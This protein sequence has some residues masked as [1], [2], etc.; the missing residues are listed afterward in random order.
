MDYLRG[1]EWRRWDLHLHTPETKKNDQYPGASA[2]EKW[3]AFY[4]A[5]ASY[6]GNADRK[7][8]DI[9]VIGITDY[10]NIDNY[11]KVCADNRLPRV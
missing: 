7:D 9:A 6:I 5:I 8:H 10:L 2:S 1:S 3:D 4:S 11:L